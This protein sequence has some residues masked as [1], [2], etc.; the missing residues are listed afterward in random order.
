LLEGSGARLRHVKLRSLDAADA[1][2]VRA[3]V[4]TAFEERR[5]ALGR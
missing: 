3:L 4:M 5:N 1:P 2:A